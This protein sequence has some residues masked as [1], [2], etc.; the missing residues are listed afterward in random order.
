M[1]YLSAS[2]IE[3]SLLFTKILG[4]PS[5]CSDCTTVF[6]CYTSINDKFNYLSAME[7]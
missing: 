5:N 4:G 3:G 2:G 6:Y 1:Y 7:S